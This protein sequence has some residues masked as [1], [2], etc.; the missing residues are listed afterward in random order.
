MTI[1]RRLYLTLEPT[2]KGGVL[3][4]IFEFFLISIIILNIFAIILDSVAELRS[5]YDVLFVKFEFFTIIFFTLE[6][7]ARIYSIFENP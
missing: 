3:E 6:Y 5:K 4:R 2:E 1:R 7:I